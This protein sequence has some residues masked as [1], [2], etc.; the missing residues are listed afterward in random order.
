M[1]YAGFKAA[2]PIDWAKLTS[3]LTTTIQGIGEK[4]EVERQELDK[5]QTENAKIL[6]NTELGKSQT[7]NELLLGG[8]GSGKENLVLWNKQLK[9]GI[10]KPLEYRNKVN[11]L[12]SNW[13]TL[14][15][16]AKTFDQQM[17]ET[18][19]L[20]QEG[21]G[22]GFSLYTNGLISEMGDLKSKKIQVDPNTGNVLIGKLNDKGMFDPNSI[23]DVRTLS[24]PGNMID[25]KLDLTAAVDAGTKN[26]K[27]FVEE[28]GITTT[29]DPRKNPAVKQAMFDLAKS[30][31]SNPRAITSVL[32]DN[33]AKQYDFYYKEQDLKNKLDERAD[34]RNEFL[35]SDGKSPMT[36][37]EREA[38]I[39]EQKKLFIP[40]VL[41]ANGTFQPNPTPEQQ[42]EALKTVSN[43]IETRLE[44]K[45]ELDEPQSS[46]GG[47]GG[48]SDSDKKSSAKS[49]AIAG[50]K[51]TL[52]AWGADV[53]ATISTGNF[54]PGDG[55]S[56]FGGL[57]GGYRYEKV[58]DANGKTIVNVYQGTQREP[59]FTAR[60][61][62]DL[63]QYAYGSSNPSK[64]SLD[65]ENARKMALQSGGSSSSAAGEGDN[66]FN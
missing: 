58:K 13:S 62:K 16:T 3:G 60:S 19:K 57:K 39:N 38:Y 48:D 37:S 30:I 35:K 25:Y 34:Y 28:K 65:W 8:A 29:T 9:A 54:V 55:G 12:M 43:T 63:A 33:T 64:A 32:V 66:I 5:L 50:Y 6:D 46:G 1:E 27:S 59:I 56:D 21:K 10:I 26:I 20:Q 22:S 53:D 36:A 15:K 11:N 52:R 17:Q 51:A 14:A 40:V 42:D 47:G 2:A 23:V 41:D 18:I 44:Y 24:Q 61:P 7:F 45:K 31:A 49:Q 4:R